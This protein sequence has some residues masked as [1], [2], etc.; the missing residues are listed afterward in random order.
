[1]MSFD[2]TTPFNAL[3][4]L[5][6]DIDLEKPALLKQAIQCT[7]YLGELK[8]LAR[9][10][11]NPAILINS[12]VL[13]ESQ[14]SSEIEN[15]VTTQDKLFQ[16]FASPN[17]KMDPQTKEVL[18]YREAIWAGYNSIKDKPLITTNLLIELS[19][20]IRE[21]KE[22]IRK[23]PGTTISRTDGTVIYTPPEGEGIIRDKLADLEKFINVDNDGLDPLIKMA[24]IHYQF[25]AIHPFA[26]GNG[27]TGRILNVLYLLLKGYLD[28]PVLYLSRMII[29]NKNAYYRNLRNITEKNLWIPWIEF[30]LTALSDT[31]RQTNEKI[32][33]ILGLFEE[34]CDRAKRDLPAYMVSRE[35]IEVLFENPYSKVQFL[36]NKNIAQRQRASVYLKELERI[37]ILKQVKAGRENLYLNVKLWEVLED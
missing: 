15:I 34:T 18:R 35:L 33:Q 25:E 5:P 26:D 29:R 9:T 11:P 22:S 19:Q 1:M 2:R 32:I 28:L 37:G 8:G 23:V 14:A 17:E 7:R 27:R 12:I 13:Q 20:I 36:V 4:P 10:M 31:A 16:A 30:V 6:P 21:V 3:P 24:L